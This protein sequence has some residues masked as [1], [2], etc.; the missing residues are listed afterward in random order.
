MDATPASPVRRFRS[1][2]ISDVHLGSR[3]C[4]A[5]SLLHFLSSVQADTLYLVGDIVDVWSLR[6]E[7]YWPAGHNE[8]VRRILAL[9]RES[10]RVIYIPGNHDE[11]MRDHAGTELS[12][13]RV[14]R[15]CV[16]R[17]ADGQRLLVTHGDEV[18]QVVQFS[19]M[20]TRIGDGA[21]KALIR[22]NT[23]I[24]RVRRVFGY[25]YWSLA[26]H[27]K[28]RVGNA[29]RYIDRFESAMASLARQQRLDG[30]I[31][32]HIHHPRVA[33][34]DGVLYCNDG[35]WVENCTALVEHA[36]G[37]LEV[38]RWTTDAAATPE[39]DPTAAAEPARHAA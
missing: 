27:L 37:R 21:Y 17:T 2:F 29:L 30:V 23:L 12:G 6:R 24:N 3:A 10:G 19:P 20:I 1:V 22:L 9:A 18:D 13:V 11:A 33:R 26:G 7:F 15:H 5:E 4:R 31:C 38:L 16:H 39:S 8:V 36:D 14:L 32:G 25:P 28:Q 34:R 35:D